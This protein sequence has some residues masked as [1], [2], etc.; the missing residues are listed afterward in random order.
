MF[1]E[2]KTP[3]D[4][5]AEE[6]A[7]LERQ[8]Q[9]NAE[10]LAQRHA[11]KLSQLTK[12]GYSYDQALVLCHWKADTHQ[13]MTLLERGCT[14]ELAMAILMPDVLPVSEEAPAP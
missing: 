12:A 7:E 2:G 5:A 14:A 3:A 6:R 10:R 4:K 11:W 1:G 8:A 13:A 9:A